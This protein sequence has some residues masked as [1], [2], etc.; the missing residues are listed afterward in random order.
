M[1]NAALTGS[2]GALGRPGLSLL[3][4]RQVP[5]ALKGQALFSSY[6]RYD[7]WPISKTN[8]ILNIVPQGHSVVVERFGKMNAVQPPGLFL[9]IPLVDRLAYLVDMRERAMEIHPQRCITKDNVS[10]DVSGNVYI[11]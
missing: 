2:K 8:T 1:I 3:L 6:G 10:V 9:A 11:Q 4:R 5:S 7:G